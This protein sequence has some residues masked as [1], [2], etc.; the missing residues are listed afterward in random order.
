MDRSKRMEGTYMT[1]KELREI[2][3]R[4]NAATPKPSNSDDYDEFICSGCG[5]QVAVSDDGE[6]ENGDMC[7][8]CMASHLNKV[9]PDIP[10]LISEVRR[11]KKKVRTE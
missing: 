6:W 11:L 8:P 2:E 9:L 4:A 1:E 5:N 10:R 3:A 7:W